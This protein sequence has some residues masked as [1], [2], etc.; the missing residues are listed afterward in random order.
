[1]ERA[2]RQA[3]VSAMMIAYCSDAGIAEPT[4]MGTGGGVYTAGGMT[5]DPNT[6]AIT[7]NSSGSG[8]VT[9]TIAAVSGCPGAQTT[10][11][12]VISPAALADAGGP[13]TSVEAAPI[14]ISASSSG[15]G[16]WSGGQG[17]LADAASASTTYTPTM[18]EIG[19]AVTLTWTT[20]DPD[21]SG[22][23]GPASDQAH[24]NV[25]F[26]VYTPMFA[27]GA[28]RGDV[29]S[30]YVTPPITADIFNGGSGRGDAAD[31]FVSAPIASSIFSGGNGR[32]DV[33]IFRERTHR[34]QHLQWWDT[35]VAMWRTFHERTHRIEHLLRWE[36]TRRC[37]GLS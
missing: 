35:G 27:G 37:R 17:V 31:L 8:T 9:Y 14:A 28:G 30:A 6:G 29:S 25:D 7:L 11:D 20:D 18:A 3:R 13:Y 23:C 19:F 10:A 16:S 1:M 34:I 24:V 12:V 2:Y 36:W 33:A 21:A 22:P 26:A 32:G 5:I 4:L 15:P